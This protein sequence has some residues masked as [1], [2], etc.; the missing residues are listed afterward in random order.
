[1]DPVLLT[2]SQSTHSTAVDVF[3]NKTYAVIAVCHRGN[4]ICCQWW[5]TVC[6]MTSC[7][8]LKHLQIESNNRPGLSNDFVAHAGIHLADATRSANSIKADGTH[9]LDWGLSG[10]SLICLI[11][12][13]K[14]LDQ[15]QK[16]RK[17]VKAVKVM[18][19][20]R[21]VV[22]YVIPWNYL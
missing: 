1:M 10:R 20:V 8:W 5:R 7:S 18:K 2:H 9:S 15:E 4:G 3:G 16:R 14:N 21:N 22:T 19:V 6:S 12:E 11:G 13:S 17:P